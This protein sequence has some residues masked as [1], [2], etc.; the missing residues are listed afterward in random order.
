VILV[1]Q[2]PNPRS[3]QTLCA[4]RK[5]CSIETWQEMRVHQSVRTHLY[6]AIQIVMKQNMGIY[7]EMKSTEL[8]DYG[9]MYYKKSFWTPA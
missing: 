7:E 3:T 4:L 9:D 1:R 2:P 8:A 5:T 6:Y